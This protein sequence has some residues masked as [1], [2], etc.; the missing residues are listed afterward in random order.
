MR[1]S[2]AVRHPETYS[3]LRI[4]YTADYTPPEPAVGWAGG[5]AAVD[6]LEAYD[7]D[8]GEPIPAAELETL[9]PTV[10]EALNA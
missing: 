2:I 5:W 1:R 4:T 9:A 8:A 10:E 3:R 6:I 7:V